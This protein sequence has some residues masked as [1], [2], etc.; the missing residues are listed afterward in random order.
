MANRTIYT[1]AYS[2]SSVGQLVSAKKTPTKGGPL[3]H[4]A[5]LEEFRNHADE[6]DREPT[7]LVSGSDR[8]VDT[9]KRAFDKHYGDGEPSAGIWIVFIE[10][11]P[12]T[13]DETATRIHSAKKLAEKCN[14]P[15]PKLFSHEVVFEWAIPETYV[16]HEVS[17]QT[18]IKRGVQENFC[19]RPS[20]AEIRRYT[21]REFQQCDDP[22]EI[23]ITL[24]FFARTFGARAPLRWVANELF[25]DCV[26]VK[27]LDDDVVRLDFAHGPTKIVDFQ[28]FCHLEDGIDTALCEWWLAL[29]DYEEFER[30]REVTEDGAAIEAEAVKIGL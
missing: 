21:A 9:L 24:G 18:L 10:V 15:E 13:T 25:H 14:L 20:T 26:L 16:L 1:R 7:A 12:T 19:L 27:I 4:A 17:L 6:W 28:Y 11:P 8:I 22:W 3:S 29:L 23:G 2:K 30:W 5:L